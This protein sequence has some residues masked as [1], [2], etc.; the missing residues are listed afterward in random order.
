M[1]KRQPQMLLEVSKREQIKAF[2]PPDYVLHVA[3]SRTGGMLSYFLQGTRGVSFM[4]Y[5]DWL[6]RLVNSAY[7][8][9]VN[10]VAIVMAM[11]EEN[12]VNG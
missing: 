5:N 2:V 9:G 1:A 8:Q 4:Q 12:Q 11:K 10:D 6:E 3:R 7:L